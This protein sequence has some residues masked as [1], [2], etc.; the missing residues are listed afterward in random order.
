MPTTRRSSWWLP[1]ISS[2]TR[3]SAAIPPSV[4]PTRP[5][6]LRTRTF[7]T[8]LNANLADH[9]QLFRRVEL[10]L[11]TSPA[12]ALPTDQR[13][14]QVAEQPDPQLAALYFQYGRYLLIASSRPG[15]Q[16]ANLQGIWNEQL[17]AAV[18]QQM[19]GEHQ[20]GD[21]LLAGRGLQPGRMP[22]AA[23]RH[24]RRRAPRRGTKRPRCTTTA[25]AGCCT[26]T[27]TSGAARRRSTLEPRHLGHRR[28]LALPAPVGALPVLPATSEF[29]AQRAYPLMKGPPQF[30]LD[31]L[32]RRSRRPA[33]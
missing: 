5:R 15:C 24:D 17:Q 16:P 23:V 26:T 11:G 21:E 7:E 3:M 30:F 28:R 6:Q 10:D 12:A 33:G 8:L 19:D 25:T 18:G 9:Q 4:V 14:K 22:R 29:L 32:V 31:F 20:H 1:P 13:L 27:P 2:T